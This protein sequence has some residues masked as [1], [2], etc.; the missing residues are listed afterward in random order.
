VYDH[1]DTVIALLRAREASAVLPRPVVRAFI[2]RAAAAAWIAAQ[3]T[4]HA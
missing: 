4:A 1:R 2:G 3:I